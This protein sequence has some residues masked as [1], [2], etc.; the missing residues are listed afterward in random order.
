MSNIDKLLN[1]YSDTENEIRA[2]EDFDL[3]TDEAKEK[4]ANIEQQIIKKVTQLDVWL[5]SIKHRINSLELLKEQ[6]KSAIS[7]ID[8]K[9]K[10]NENTIKYIEENTLPKL[11]NA[12]G[13]LDT[14]YKKYTIYE[15]DGA[16]EILDQSQVPTE[17]IRTKI[18][19]SIDKINLK[20]FIKENG[21]QSYAQIPRV[22]KVK[23]T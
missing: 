15:T 21:N 18:E 16:I 22:K 19:Q 2:L 6:F 13:K 17:F 23:V 7:S 4:L 5:G 10:Q 1:L 3:D 20:K 12:K 11:V 9:I 8:K 14:G